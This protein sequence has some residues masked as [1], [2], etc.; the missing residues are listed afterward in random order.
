MHRPRVRRQK[1]PE[2]QA[3]TPTARPAFRWPC[4]RFGPVRYPH[5]HLRRTRRSARMPPARTRRAFLDAIASRSGHD[6]CKS[7]IMLA[8]TKA[9]VPRAGENRR[10]PGSR[11][12]P[13][14]HAAAGA[15]H[16]PARTKTRSSQAG[17]ACAA[18]GPQPRPHEGGSLEIGITI[19]LQKF[20]RWERPPYGDAPDLLLCW[21]AHRAEIDG[22]AFLVLVN[23]ANRFAVARETDPAARFQ[24]RLTALANATPGRCA[25]HAGR[26][27][28]C[29]TMREDLEALAAGSQT[30]RRHAARCLPSSQHAPGAA[31]H[32]SQPRE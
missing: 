22:R 24:R 8:R 21:D 17:S 10:M 9:A 7:G 2:R 5:R 26:V 25:A 4:L 28:A 30:R 3:T 31:A 23:S 12:A 18:N 16:P 15:H 14:A 1:P 6:G 20:L 11:C 27:A 32:G 13:P 29:A 19:P